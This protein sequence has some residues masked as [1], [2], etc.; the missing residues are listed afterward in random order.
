MYGTS[1]LVSAPAH[2]FIDDDRA[3]WASSSSRPGDVGVGPGDVGVSGNTKDAHPDR[4]DPPTQLQVKSASNAPWMDPAHAPFD[5][6]ALGVDDQL[7][8]DPTQCF[9]DMCWAAAVCD[10]SQA[11]P[12]REHHDLHLHPELESASPALV[13]EGDPDYH[14]DQHEREHDDHNDGRY[15]EPEDGL[16]EQ[17]ENDYGGVQAAVLAAAAFNK[18]SRFGRRPM[19]TVVWATQVPPNSLPALLASAPTPRTR[20]PPPEPLA[21]KLNVPAAL[22]RLAEESFSLNDFDD[23]DAKLNWKPDDRLPNSNNAPYTH[24]T[25]TASYA[26]SLAASNAYTPTSTSYAQTHTSA[27][28]YAYT[29]LFAPFTPADP[30]ES[31]G[32]FPTR[33]DLKGRGSGSGWRR[34]RASTLPGRVFRYFSFSS[35]RVGVRS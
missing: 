35:G 6:T 12:N 7:L 33:P 14:Y 5:F 4:D 16:E 34:Q 32:F 21:N 13:G 31:I 1:S 29:T 30:S 17:D 23:F 25:H 18:P 27:N 3:P 2:A 28:S 10:L 22:K 15:D 26:N 8:H 24:N 9:A 20:T 11:S 19:S